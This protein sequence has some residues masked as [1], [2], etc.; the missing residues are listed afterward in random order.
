MKTK[1]PTAL[2]HTQTHMHHTFTFLTAP[3]N[4]IKRIINIALLLL[5]KLI[6]LSW[7][8]NLK[9][10]FLVRGFDQ[11]KP[12]KGSESIHT[13]QK[14]ILG[15]LNPSRHIAQCDWQKGNYLYWFLNIFRQKKNMWS[16]RHSHTHIYIIYINIYIHEHLHGINSQQR[17]NIKDNYYY[18]SQMSNHIRKDTIIIN[19][20]KRSWYSD[21]KRCAK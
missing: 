15:S 21:G 10:S 14:N 18:A 4:P 11:R 1:H 19:R 17:N 16:H 5:S 3:V 13:H 8:C 2:L 6:L 12:V 9:F 20:E 7:Y